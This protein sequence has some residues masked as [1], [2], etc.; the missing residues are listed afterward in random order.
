MLSAIVV[1]G[2]SS[3]RM[4]F[5]KLFTPLK[6]EPVVAHA[7]AAF[8]ETRSVSEI[9]V[10]GREESLAELERLIGRRNFSKVTAV[11]SGGARRQDSVAR[12]LSGVSAGSAY[13]AVHDAARPLV[14]PEL[15][16]QIFQ[17]AQAEGGAASGAPISD[18]LKRVNAQHLVVG[19]V[20]RLNLFAVETP[21]IFRRELLQE[22]FQFI[23]AQ[24][25]DVTDEI[26]A[27]EKIGGKVIIVPN[28]S[29][30]FKITYESDRE[31]AEFIL[32]QRAD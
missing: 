6:G 18:T 3:R 16:E 24:G 15:I 30:N 2:G 9:I 31:R 12:G 1:A 17:A 13:V 19:G 8:Q 22:A 11:I 26:S 29:P 14:R 23:T 4:G 28:D 32:R 10:V 27:V 5:D 20:D 7:L 21:Q 25:L